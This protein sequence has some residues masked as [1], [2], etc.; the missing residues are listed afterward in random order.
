[1]RK[2]RYIPHP[3]DAIDLDLRYDGAFNEITIYINDDGREPF[4]TQVNDRM[5]IEDAYAVLYGESTR[6][7]E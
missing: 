3:D 5:T 7:P 2:V 6:K 1:M 4:V